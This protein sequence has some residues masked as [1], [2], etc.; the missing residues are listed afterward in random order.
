MKSHKNKHHHS[1]KTRKHKAI[2]M[3]GCLGK[4]SFSSCAVCK[5]RH[6]CCVCGKKHSCKLHEQK[7]HEIKFKDIHH[8][9]PTMKLH[10]MGG[11]VPTLIGAPWTPTNLPGQAGLD[12]Q[13]NYYALNKYTPFD[14]QTEN[15]ISER[16]QMTLGGARRRA[17]RTM[18][19]GG[20]LI[21]QDLVNLGRNITYGVGSAYNAINGYAAPVNP[22]PYNGQLV[23]LR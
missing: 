4:A 16:N 19:R 21:P 22:M 14:P 9:N 17:K 8:A 1:K 2:N 11:N 5:S 10:M 6:A 7:Q 3:R 20:G 15:I 18:K 12:G 23:Q 13:T